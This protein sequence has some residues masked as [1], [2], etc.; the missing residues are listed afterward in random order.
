MYQSEVLDTSPEVVGSD[1]DVQYSEW[2]ELGASP[3]SQQAECGAQPPKWL[4]V[5]QPF[6][7]PRHFPLSG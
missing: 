6:L 1:F 7:H 3:S 2:I 4:Q 5:P